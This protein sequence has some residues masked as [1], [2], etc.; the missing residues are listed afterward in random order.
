MFSSRH[1]TVPV[2]NLDFL[3]KH[4]HPQGYRLVH[5]RQSIFMRFPKFFHHANE[6]HRQCDQK[7]SP[8]SMK[9]CTKMMSLEK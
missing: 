4:N 9:S 1:Q 5:A 2:S 6:T 7:K 8:M 3:K